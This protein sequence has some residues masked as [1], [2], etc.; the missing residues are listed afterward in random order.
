MTIAVS[1]FGLNDAAGWRCSRNGVGAAMGTNVT[2]AVPQGRRSAAH[3]QCRVL[4][5]AG[6]L[7]S[8]A[9]AWAA[10]ET[11]KVGCRASILVAEEGQIVPYLNACRFIG[12][13]V[14]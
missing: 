1:L 9:P 13:T 2:E 5:L 8:H 4:R 10:W 3:G 11:A 7:P 12:L 6:I 14:A